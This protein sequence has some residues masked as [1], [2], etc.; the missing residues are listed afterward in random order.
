M[1][2]SAE[3]TSPPQRTRRT[4]VSKPFTNGCFLRVPRV[5]R[6]GELHPSAQ[7]LLKTY[8]RTELNRA[9]RP[10]ARDHAEV[11]RAEREAGDFEIRPV[12]QV[13]RFGA[14]PDSDA[15]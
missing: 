13:V 15:I 5:L 9:R 12:E 4:G 1:K 3:K 10:R 11:G 8:P 6:G 7:P 2:I 14:K